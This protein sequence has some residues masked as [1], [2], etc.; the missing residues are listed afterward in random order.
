METPQCKPIVS[1]SWTFS[2]DWFKA[3][4][5][6]PSELQNPKNTLKPVATAYLGWGQLCAT[7][8]GLQ[9][10]PQRASPNLSKLW[11]AEMMARSPF[12]T[13]WRRASSVKIGSLLSGWWPSL[14][15]PNWI[16]NS[17]GYVGN[18]MQCY[19][20]ERFANVHLFGRELWGNVSENMDPYIWSEKASSKAFDN[21]RFWRH[22][23]A[24]KI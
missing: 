15:L 10:L 9:C 18:S 13:V 17:L 12:H 14:Q 4:R 3:F 11:Q 19:V 20:Y 5:W 7:P 22:A 16:S 21:K 24:N 6:N 8:K 1:V 2:A 23:H